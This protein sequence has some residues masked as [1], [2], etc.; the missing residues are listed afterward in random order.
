VAAAASAPPTSSPRV[1]N[2]VVAFR[3]TGWSGNEA[4]QKTTFVNVPAGP[5][6]GGGGGGGSGGGNGGGGGGGKM[7]R[8]PVTI[9][10]VPYSEH[11]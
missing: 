4:H 10:H 3:P 8:V 11:S 9:H 7:R 2:S 1:F 5:G 6:S